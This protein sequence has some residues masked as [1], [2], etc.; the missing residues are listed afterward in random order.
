MRIY[1]VRLESERASIFEG[2]C[3]WSLK[4]WAN[5]L[6]FHICIFMIY[7]YIVAYIFHSVKLNFMNFTLRVANYIARYAPSEKKLREYLTKKH[8]QNIDTLLIEYGYSEVMMMSLWIRTFLSTGTALSLARRRLFL[9]GFPKELIET[10]LLE[11]GEEF[12][13]WSTIS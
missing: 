7:G 9:K 10:T 12:K 8:C 6:R 4:I 13:D 2:E 1:A 11:V 5:I 3:M